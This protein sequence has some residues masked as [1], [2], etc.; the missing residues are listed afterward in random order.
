MPVSSRNVAQMLPLFSILQGLEWL[1]L[2]AAYGTIPQD[3]PH[4]HFYNTKPVYQQR[5]LYAG[6]GIMGFI[7]SKA[8]MKVL[9][10]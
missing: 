8:K 5:E 6:F 2:P 7:R 1:M 9:Y 4:L 3:G 10:F